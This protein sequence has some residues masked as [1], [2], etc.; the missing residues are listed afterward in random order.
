MYSTALTGKV[1]SLSQRTYSLNVACQNIGLKAKIG[2]GVRL[3]LWIIKKR[4]SL[5]IRVWGKTAEQ[6]RGGS[7][8]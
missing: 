1:F 8:R 3:L 6:E 2:K 5:E 4:V 7:D